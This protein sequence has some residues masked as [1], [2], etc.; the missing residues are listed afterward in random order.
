[1]S[2]SIPSALP[3]EQPRASGPGGSIGAKVRHSCSARP[4][5]GPRASERKANYDAVRESALREG[6]ARDVLYEDHPVVRND[7]RIATPPV[8]E[9]YDIVCQVIVHRDPGTC[10]IAQAR[11]GKTTS[12]AKIKQELAQT[13][14]GLP[15]GTV[16]AVG[17]SSRSERVLFGDILAD[18]QHS[19]ARAGTAEE[20][21]DRLAQL[22]L[23]E[24]RAAHSERYL[25]LVDEGQNWDEDE[26][27]AL[28]D[29]TNSVRKLGI[30]VIT[31]IFA[32]PE[33]MRLRARLQA[34][35][36][37]DLIGRFLLTPRQFRGLADVEEL[38][39]TL[40]AFDDAGI[41]RYPEHSDIC[42][43]E[44]FMPFAYASG[45]RLSLEADRLWSAFDTVSRRGGQPGGNLGMQWVLG[46]VRN[47]LFSEA[48]NDRI[49]FD[50]KEQS[51]LYAVEAS[52][53]EA[54]LWE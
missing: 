3:N 21:R 53:Y 26:Y 6:S 11:I 15:V 23:A 40:I 2:A 30:A 16:I 12:I 37:T 19:R 51:W 8:Q 47:F 20:R 49:A 29:V 52:G 35:R 4:S 14:P 9:A 36:R 28:R 38:R 32:H 50:G 27:N 10:L 39:R 42:Y 22:W 34:R 45:W 17:H 7:V 44:F 33:L 13:F 46:A 18:Y 5:N 48:Q 43:S 1:M 24:C 31:V 25:L 41:H 54:A